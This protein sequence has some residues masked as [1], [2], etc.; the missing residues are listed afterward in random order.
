MV[1]WGFLFTFHI[2]FVLRSVSDCACANKFRQAISVEYALICTRVC[3]GNHIGVFLQAGTN[4]VLLSQC[5]GGK[6]VKVSNS[7]ETNI[8]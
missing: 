1:S 8:F 2:A 4:S 7:Y 6:E 3:Q 5:C